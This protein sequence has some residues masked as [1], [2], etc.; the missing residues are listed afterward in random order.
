MGVRKSI[1][2]KKSNAQPRAIAISRSFSLKHSLLDRSTSKCM[3]AMFSNV[4]LYPLAYSPVHASN[5]YTHNGIWWRM[6]KTC[7][8]L[9]KSYAFTPLACVYIYIC[10]SAQAAATKTTPQSL[11]VLRIILISL[12]WNAHAHRNAQSARQFAALGVFPYISVWFV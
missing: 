11:I 2:D 9:P 10:V 12:H 4:V 7:T 5:T 8:E 6:H 1:G 3:P